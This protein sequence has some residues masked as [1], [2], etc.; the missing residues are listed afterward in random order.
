MAPVTPASTPPAGARS[1]LPPASGRTAAAQGPGRERPA[2]LTRD[3]GFQRLTA[4]STLK[5]IQADATA[6]SAAGVIGTPYV[7]VGTRTTGPDKLT[8]V[9]VES[10]EKLLTP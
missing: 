8:P 6:G 4:P 2:P 3:R 7:L 5:Q 9:T 1:Q 10:F